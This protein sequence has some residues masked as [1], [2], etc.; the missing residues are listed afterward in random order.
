MS[1]R[2][3]R[4][5]SLIV[6]IITGAAFC[7]LCWWAMAIF[8]PM[9]I[10]A[11]CFTTIYVV[12]L[13]YELIGAMFGYKKTLS[14]RYKH[15]LQGSTKNKIIGFGGLALFWIAMTA[16]VVHLGVFW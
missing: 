1:G 7:G 15:F 16:L 5:L 8:K 6:L 3:I 4:Q 9:W 12:V 11:A 14:T 10:P 13:I 2:L